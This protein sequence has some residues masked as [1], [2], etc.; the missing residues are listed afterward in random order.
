MCDVGP[1]LIFL[2]AP[3]VLTVG[4]TMPLDATR[5]GKEHKSTPVVAA[6][7]NREGW[8]IVSV[9]GKNLDDSS[10]DSLSRDSLWAQYHGEAVPIQLD[11]IGLMIRQPP[12]A[13]SNRSYIIGLAC[14][15]IGM[16]L[17]LGKD[18]QLHDLGDWSF[19]VYGAEFSG[20]MLLGAITGLGVGYVIDRSYATVETLD[21]TRESR[22]AK[23]YI[24]E[25]VIS[26]AN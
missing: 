4:C 16:G 8:T 9:S 3:A 25:K 13:L 2:L 6:Y 18:P 12:V 22:S 20:A 14:S 23:Y 24:I 21:L 7:E 26:R 19:A 11:S 1:L 5:Q 15:A 10:I 17:F